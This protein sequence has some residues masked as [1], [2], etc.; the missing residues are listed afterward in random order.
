ML[1]DNRGSLTKHQL[2]AFGALLLLV[3]GAAPATET[4][5]PV[6]V[7]HEN[8]FSWFSISRGAGPWAW[9]LTRME[10]EV[11]GLAHG[12]AD[13]KLLLRREQEG[14]RPLLF[15][16]LAAGAGD[17]RLLVS[18]V[19][20]DHLIE[21]DLESGSPRRATFTPRTFFGAGVAWNGKAWVLAGLM[22]GVIGVQLR[23]PTSLRVVATYPLSETE[24][25]HLRRISYEGSL[26]AGADGRVV[27]AFYGLGRAIVLDPDAAEAL[28]LELPIPPDRTVRSA[29][30]VG[31]PSIPDE[32]KQLWAGRVAPTG[33]GWTG[34]DPSVL[35]QAPDPPSSLTWCRFSGK[36]GRLSAMY[37]L[38]IPFEP[39]SG[40][41]AASAGR[42][43][44]TSLMVLRTFPSGATW[45]SS[46]YEYW[47]P[48]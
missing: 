41:K 36:D 20:N 11:Y 38:E 31:V 35:L 15:S 30:R 26:A 12:A 16:A 9:L 4:L 18:D 29:G 27:V 7:V 8:R 6:R 28:S 5:R 17:G 43:G 14:G 10:G 25:S 22:D 48:R 19:R 44:G 3:A 33:V 42:R 34:D 46:L 1:R 32:V 13:A 24:R 37:S 21:A 47:I 39:R 40:Y 45:R 23:E 2:G